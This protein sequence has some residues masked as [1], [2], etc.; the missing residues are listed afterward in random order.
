GFVAVPYAFKAYGIPALSERLRHPV[1]LS[2]VTFNPFTFALTL[3]SFEIQ[4]SNGTPMLG[5]QELLVN[6]EGTSLVKSSF[7]FD[8]IHLKLPFGLIHIRADGKLNLLDLVPLPGEPGEPSPAGSSENAMKRSM[9]PVEVRSLIIQ[10]G[11]LE[12]KDDSKRKPITIHVV[13]IEITL[14]NFSTRPGGENAYAF[15]A[16]FGEGETLSWE[17]TLHLDPLKS[18]GHVSLS[19]AKLSTF[20]PSIRDRFRFDIL[21]GAVMVD[22]RYHFDTSA[23]PVNFRLT[24]GKIVL[25]DFRLAA[26]GDRNPIMTVP[27]L[28]LDAIRLDLPKH[29]LGVDTIRM[30]GAEIRTWLAQDG[31]LN[32]TPLLTPVSEEAGVPPESNPASL[33]SVKVHQVE[34]EKAHIGFEDRSVK[35]PVAV[36]IDDIHATVDDIHM[37]FKGPFQVTAN[38]RLNEQ[39]TVHGKGTMQLNPLQADLVVNLKHIALRPFQPYFDRA[40]NVD[41]KDG[42]LEVTGEAHYRTPNESEPMLRYT[43]QVGVNTLHV[44]DAVTHKEFLSWATLGLSKVAFTFAPTSVKIG[45]LALRE[46]AV[47][48][49]IGEDGSINIARAM[50]ATDP[51]AVQPRAARQTLKVAAQKEAGPM[52]I[53]IDVV[54]LSKLSATFVDESI[55]PTVTTGIHDLS[56]TIKGLSSRQV[57]KA[58]VS[59]A[60]KIDKV[61]PLKIQGQINPLSEEAFTNLR[62]IFQGVDLTAVS[63]YAGKY[64]GYPIAKGKL[65][66][67]LKYQVSKKQLV[68]ENK[69][70]VDQFAFGDKTGS[71]EATGLPV[72]LAVG[73]LQDRHGRID[74]DMPVRGD[75]N[76]PDFRYGRVVLNALVNLIT[77]VATS[78]FSA[79]GRL[80]GGGDEDLQFIEFQAGAEALESA[81]Q[82]KIESISK[83]LQERPALRVEVIGVAD[84]SRDRQALA[85]QKINAEVQRRFTKAGTKNLQAVIS[86]Q[87]EFEFLSDLYAEKLGKQPT[88]REASQGGTVVERVVSV[89]ELRQQ[90]I[91]AMTVEESE[92]RSLAQGR[93]KAI[94]E[95]LI[96][97][98]RLP[99]DRVFL[100]EVELASSE[101]EMV[102]A[103]LNLTGN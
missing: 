37:P 67:D 86:Q 10:Q 43:G 55:E 83:A 69:V 76:E 77:K 90:L 81:G 72:R 47:V 40:A 35:T 31:V 12:V 32:F 28:T 23:A 63:S 7:V 89:E 65:S 19:R 24:D 68:G 64:A 54:T 42:E 95:Q 27:L 53:A 96:A 5:F 33:W 21:S 50:L 34:V 80:V 17:G 100:V 51:S 15:T 103:R 22:A 58:E 94:R 2:D 71:P 92:L 30:T 70:L 84:Q 93:A 26:T 82:Q 56:G 44:A 74:I 61:A 45:E 13:P 46:P 36:T 49:V 20:W 62:F 38:L 11:V 60:G 98:G 16:E 59:L 6:F 4:E 18:T 75:L 25:S 8:E 73:L 91:P 14:R 97:Q 78:P 41:V 29:E 87:R 99:E 102:R 48:F 52:P 79:L 1:F 3:S 66:L 101:G 88:K 85:R 39:G 9:P 57:A